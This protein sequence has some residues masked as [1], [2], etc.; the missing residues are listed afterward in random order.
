MWV[1]GATMI[2]GLVTTDGQPPLVERYRKATARF[3][4][5]NDQRVRRIIETPTTLL[6]SFGQASDETL[7]EVIDTGSAHALWIGTRYLMQTSSESRHTSSVT[8]HFP[9]ELAQPGHFATASLLDGKDVSLIQDASGLC[10]LYICRM[11]HALLFS[12][13]LEF[14]L[15]CMHDV[16][17]DNEALHLFAEFDTTFASQTL[18]SG[19]QQLAA[20]NVRISVANQKLHIQA[21][22]C[23][24]LSAA[25]DLFVESPMDQRPC[26]T[27]DMLSST[28]APQAQA[29]AFLQMPTHTRMHSM[30]LR[31]YWECLFTQTLLAHR[32]RCLQVS[33][34]KALF[35]ENSDDMFINGHPSASQF[36]L[37]GRMPS[38]QQ[39][40]RHDAES[41]QKS[42]AAIQQERLHLHSL[43]G[44]SPSRQE[45]QAYLAIQYQLPALAQRL[46]RLARK[47]GVMLVFPYMQ[48]A[49]SCLHSGDNQRVKALLTRFKHMNKRMLSQHFNYD[50]SSAVNLYDA[51]Q[52]L[53]KPQC[54]A[55][56]LRHF[57][58][59][60]AVQLSRYF[61]STHHRQSGDA[62][63]LATW[64]LTFD[65]LDGIYRFNTQTDDIPSTKRKIS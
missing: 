11:E 20:N 6:T 4:Q 65:Y 32:G 2:S 19:V 42:E 47:Y 50:A 18:Y 44:Q 45:W 59:I 9:V 16:S 27:E 10:P 31:N 25:T 58:N 17:L 56:T 14:L 36:S 51:A 29:T 15:L 63:S 35:A 53:L 23:L 39:W 55:S 30:P 34:G 37:R 24:S 7:A 40:L 52:R 8:T 57:F 33:M 26:L 28:P 13:S 62:L 41:Q 1:M 22:E 12:S 54:N 3:C 49:H 5:R 46:S 64:L 48:Q 61:S 43:L 60:N 38:L 21:L